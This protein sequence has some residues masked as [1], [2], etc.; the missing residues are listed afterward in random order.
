MNGDMFVCPSIRCYWL[1][2]NIT[3]IHVLLSLGAYGCSMHTLF[4]R[5]TWYTH[6]FQHMM[7]VVY[8][9]VSKDASLISTLNYHKL[10]I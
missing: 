8:I 3:N 7:G 10:T 4:V 9:Y 1:L 6:A 5:Y 2:V